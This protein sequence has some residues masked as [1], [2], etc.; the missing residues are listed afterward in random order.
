MSA[1][2]RALSWPLRASAELVGAS[3]HWFDVRR[4]W[5]PSVHER[6]LSPA[7]RD[8]ALFVTGRRLR[9]CAFQHERAA[10]TPCLL[11]RLFHRDCRNLF[12]DLRGHRRYSISI[13]HG[14]HLHGR[15][16]SHLDCRPSHS[17][18]PHSLKGVRKTAQTRAQGLV[19]AQRQ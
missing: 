19:H 10:G 7:V 17:T 14:R 13:V 4:G 18:R 16:C 15:R 12:S 5:H 3:A 1:S 9:E 11:D 8:G 2:S 6:Q